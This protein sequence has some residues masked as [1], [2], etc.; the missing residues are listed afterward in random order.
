MAPWIVMEAWDQERFHVS[1]LKKDVKNLA[2]RKHSPR[3]ERARVASQHVEEFKASDT[4]I[5]T[6]VE[7]SGKALESSLRSA[8]DDLLKLCLEVDPSKIPTFNILDKL[9]VTRSV[10]PVPK[11]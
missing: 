11:T 5:Q 8:R 3:K 2:K 1:I 7:R 9:D 4:F 6:L 10:S